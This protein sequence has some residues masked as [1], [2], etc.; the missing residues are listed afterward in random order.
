MR[1]LAKTADVFT[2]SYR[3]TVNERFGLQPDAQ[4]AR[5]KRGIVCMTVSAYGHQGPW[6]DRP[7]F[8]QNGQVASGFAIREGGSGK[9]KFS[10]VFYLA[11]LITAYLAAAGMMPALLRRAREG[12]SYHVKLSLSQSAIITMHGHSDATFS[13]MLGR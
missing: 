5:S 1:S 4:A 3:R 9:P 7:G 12:G 6:A 8:D 10:P 11:D 13:S 2:T